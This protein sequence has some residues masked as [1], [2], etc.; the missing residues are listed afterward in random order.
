MLHRQVSE[1]HLRTSTD[2]PE[3]R[4]IYA[5]LDLGSALVAPSS[6][7]GRQVAALVLVRGAARESFSEDD[8]PDLTDLASRTG[9]VIDNLRRYAR[10]HAD[11]LTLQ[12]ALLTAPVQ[13]PGLEIVSR[14][15]PADYGAQVGGDWYDS[16]TQPA[17]TIVVIGDVVGHDMQ[18]AA[19]MGQLRG[20][21]RTIGHAVGGSPSDTLTRADAVARGLQ[22]DVLASAVLARFEPAE[23]R[24]RFRLRWSNAGHPPP[25]LIRR[26]GAVSSLTAPTDP[27]LGAAVDLPR[28]DHVA[29]LQAGDTVLLY[30]DGLIERRDEGID[31]GL[32]RLA[33]TLEAAGAMALDALCE[34]VLRRSG[35]GGDDV[36]LVAVRVRGDGVTGVTG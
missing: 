6:A 2:D 20:V 10:E 21:I 12:H 22:V 11:S 5:Q 28:H 9:I 4:A 27:L 26:D 31:D 17:G 8:R 32:A 25:F 14:Y 18:A 3:V 34:L 35:S 16:F 30:T 15:V 23:G 1:E 13:S 29:H 36:A 33:R 24:G 19:S 7:R